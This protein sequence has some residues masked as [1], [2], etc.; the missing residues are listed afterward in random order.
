MS[1]W[2]VGTGEFGALL[3]PHLAKKFDFAHVIT[4]NPTIGNRLKEE[5]SP[6]ER[7]ALSLGLPLSRTERFSKDNFFIEELKQNPPNA[8]FV[9]DFGEKIGEPF[10]SYPKFGCLNIHPSFLPKYRGAAPIQRALENGDA[11]IGVT[12]FRLVDEMDAGAIVAQT[13][14][15]FPLTAN[16]SDVM[17]RM[18]VLGS[19]L[20]SKIKEASFELISQ[21]E[22]DVSFAPKI[23]KKESQ[24]SFD[25]GALALHNRVRAFF[26]SLCVW[27]EWAGKR[28][29]LI[30]TLPSDQTGETGKIVARDEHGNPVVGCADGTIILK[31]VQPEGKRVMSG[32]EWARGL[33]NPIPSVN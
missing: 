10:L 30:E 17:F 11:E 4:K 31:K 33:K 12:L 24:Q 7:V 21:N 5:I 25:M 8:I 9:I 20:A 22:S 13:K 6:V 2:F 3:L 16:A 26:P 18:A 28:V 14:E 32:S 29:K 23:L 1:Y 27:V 19:E 15:N